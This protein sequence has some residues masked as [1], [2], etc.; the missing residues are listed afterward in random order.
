MTYFEMSSSE[1]EYNLAKRFELEA[2]NIVKRVKS[3]KKT[4]KKHLVFNVVPI[5]L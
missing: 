3:V 5:I 2:I 1:I 4:L